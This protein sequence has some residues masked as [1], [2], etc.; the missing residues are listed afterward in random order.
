MKHVGWKVAFMIL[1]A[2]ILFVFAPMLIVPGWPQSGIFSGCARG[3]TDNE[4]VF[5]AMQ[6]ADSLISDGLCERAE[7]DS[8]SLDMIGKSL[9]SAKRGKALIR[10]MKRV[11]EL[12]AS[13]VALY[14]LALGYELESYPDSALKCLQMAV[15]LGDFH[16]Y[17]PGEIER[18]PSLAQDIEFNNLVPRSETNYDVMIEEARAAAVKR[19]QDRLALKDRL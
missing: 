1:G 10:E 18:F 19:L 5:M 12:E 2:G 7:R 14:W 6:T 13:S 8:L 11:P 16:L 9:G 15:S 4:L 17:L 3:M